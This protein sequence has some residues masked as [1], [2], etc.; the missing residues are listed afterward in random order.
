MPSGS[1]DVR[2]GLRL[3]PDVIQP[4]LLRYRREDL[5]VM[6][7]FVGHPDYEAVEAMIQS[8]EGGEFSIRAILTRHDQ[9]QID[10]VNDTALLA[11]SRGVQREMYSRPIGLTVEPPDHVRRARLEFKSHADEHIVLDLTTV[12][13]PDPRGGGLTDPGRHSP[14][15]SLP[16]MWR[17]ASTLAGPQTQV[18]ID[19]VRYGVPVKVRSG[20]FVA[21][22]GYYT[23]GHTMGVIRAGTVTGRLLR[24]PDRIDVG[25]EWIFDIDEHEVAYRVTA[26]EPDGQWRIVKLDGSGEMII[27]HAVDRRLEVTRINLPVDV[28]STGGLALAFDGAADFSLSMDETQD[29][30]TGDVDIAERAGSSVVSLRPAQPG[31]A[32]DRVVRVTCSGDGERLTFATTIGDA[33]C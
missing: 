29:L 12:G 7:F 23:E 33:V 15:S 8:R 6:A 10:H 16:L 5:H 20:S 9:T 17:G 28:R 3:P 24:R 2:S 14:T 31:W 19:G 25:A 4:F 11:Q 13:Q 27:A 32:T 22:Q 21:H 30:V 1:P 26:R 18:S